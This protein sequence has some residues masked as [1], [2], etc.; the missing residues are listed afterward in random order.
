MVGYHAAD[1][2]LWAEIMNRLNIMAGMVTVLMY[3][4]LIYS[5]PPLPKKEIDY[6][7]LIKLQKEREADYEV[8]KVADAYAKMT[9]IER[10]RGDAELIYH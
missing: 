6:A 10:M 8:K 9:D 5:P 2:I 7:E 1:W 4:S 3:C